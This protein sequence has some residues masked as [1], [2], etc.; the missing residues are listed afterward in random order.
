M[1]CVMNISNQATADRKKITKSILGVLDHQKV[2]KCNKNF[3]PQSARLLER[4]L[5][6]IYVIFF[7][8][9]R[10]S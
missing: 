4:R 6:Y 3:F 5:F 10:M 1:S 7:F 2:L 8:H 9:V